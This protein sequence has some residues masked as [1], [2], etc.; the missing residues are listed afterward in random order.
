MA[1]NY[2]LEDVM[3]ALRNADAAGDTKAAQRLAQIAS[4]MAPPPPAP[5]SAGEVAAGAV[6]NFLPSL[7]NLVGD[8]VTAVT[9][10]A[11]TAKSILDVGAGALQNVLPERFVQAVGEDKQSR[12]AARAVGKFYADRYGTG[13]NLKRAIAED[14]AGVLADLSTVLS[15]GAMAAPRA[16]GRPLAAAASYVDPLAMTAR[17]VAGTAN[18]AGRVAAPVLG[19]T[20]GAGREAIRGAFQAGEKGGKTAEQ[21][22]ANISGQADPTKVLDLARANLQEMNRLK[23]A[24]YRSG[25]VDIKNDRSLLEFNDID[26]AIKDGFGIVNFGGKTLKESA[27]QNLQKAQAIVDDWKNSDPAVFHTPEGFDAMKQKIGDVLEQISIEQKSARGVVGSLYN[28]VKDT[29]QAQAPTYSKVMKD[30]SDASDKIMEIQKTLSL[31]SKS[32][33][34]T[35]MRK[36][37][38]LMRDNVQTNYGQRIKLGQELEKVGGK[39]FMPGL[40][41]QALANITPRGLQTAT[42]VPTGYLAY[43]AAGIPGAA[44]SLAT[45]SPR[46]MGEAAYGAGAAARRLQ[47]LQKRFPLITNPQLYNY[48]YQSGQLQGLLGE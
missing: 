41:G 12:D 11:E 37:Q 4:S 1:Q 32:S 46:V 23:Q 21:F 30:Y 25:M 6:T 16:V 26:K 45:S 5:L 28:S 9:N 43:G 24:E 35:A 42:A 22:R 3:Q 27:A 17:G 19:M 34:D 13:E 2:T 44:M 39:E 40:A 18:L 29:I 20:T 15:G 8:I 47:E 7:K 10:P 48:L 14:P 36:L 38:S 31:N 33:T